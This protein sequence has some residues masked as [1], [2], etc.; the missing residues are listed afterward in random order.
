MKREALQFPINGVSKDAAKAEA[1]RIKDGVRGALRLVKPNTRLS[2]DVS[3]M[4]R[5]F[6]RGRQ[7]SGDVAFA[8]IAAVVPR[9][10]FEQQMAFWQDLAQ[11]V[12][13]APINVLAGSVAHSWEQETECQAAADIAQQRG[14]RAVESGNVREIERAELATL[15]AAASSNVLAMKFRQARELW[16]QKPRV[17]AFG[18]RA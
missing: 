3:D 15:A 11:R 13:S 10:T 18:A 8:C 4:V 17:V 12:A 9:L 16:N 7:A 6:V 5:D 1:E 2:G 14:I